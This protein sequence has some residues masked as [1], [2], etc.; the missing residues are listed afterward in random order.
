MTMKQTIQL[1]TDAVSNLRVD[2]SGEYFSCYILLQLGKHNVF[3]DLYT[4]FTLV[5]EDTNPDQHPHEVKVMKTGPDSFH[6]LDQDNVRHALYL[7]LRE[8]VAPFFPRN[9]TKF[10]FFT[11]T[12]Q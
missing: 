6:Y 12:K 8:F 2:G 10:L 1:Y 9:E 4:K 3:Q 7:A 5:V 11:L